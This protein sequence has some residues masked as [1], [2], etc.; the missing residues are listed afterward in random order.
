M[1]AREY[2]QEV[3]ALDSTLVSIEKVLDLPKLQADALSLEAEASAPDLWNDPEKAQVVTSKLSRVQSTLNRITTIR[4]RLEDVASGSSAIVSVISIKVRNVTRVVHFPMRLTTSER[5]V[6]LPGSVISCTGIA[7]STPEKRVAGLFA[8]RGTITVI[9]GAGLIGRTTGAIRSDFRNI[10]LRVGG[11]SG[12]L[13]P[14]LVLGDTSLETHT[15]VN[16]MLLAGLTHLTAVSG[17]NFAIIAAFMIWVLQWIVPNLRARLVICAVVLLGFIFLVRPSPSVLRA[18]VM[19]SVVLIAKARGLRTS[20]LAALGLAISL[21]ILIDPFEAIDPGFALSVAATGGILLLT[22]P[23]A[24]WLFRYLRH[25]KIAELLA[26]SIAA[27]IF[28]TPLSVAISG[29]FSLMSLP[30]NFLVEPVV[31]P[32]TVVGFIAALLAPF[33]SGFSYLLTLTQKPFSSVIVWVATTFAKVPVVHLT[34]G[35]AG[36]AIAV[37]VLGCGY[38]ALRWRSWGSL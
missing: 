19:V 35:F 37:A 2:L 21:L 17:E 32:I 22:D 10:S 36:A 18:T 31:A 12:A 27:N 11:A 14:G 6:A 5:F 16:D 26:I 9:H 25:R 33:A 38:I 13:I 28:C 23:V 15:F 30:S 7:Y 3:R 34:K 20:A 8:A 29:Q 4:R 24:D 1:A